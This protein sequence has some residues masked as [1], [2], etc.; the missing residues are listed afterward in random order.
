M[1]LP[2]QAAEDPSRATPPL[3]AVRRHAA[4]GTQ[5]SL[6]AE[7]RPAVPTAITRNASRYVD[8][9]S[10][11]RA[12]GRDPVS[13]N[14][15][16]VCYLRTGEVAEALRLF[17]GLALKPGCTWERSDIPELY[18]RNFATALLMSGLPSGCLA[19]LRELPDQSSP[20]TQQ[21]Y[22]AVR[23]WERT[24]SFWARWD[25]RWNAIEPKGCHV[26]IDFEPGEFAEE[27]PS[28][29]SVG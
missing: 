5:D 17:R 23:R 13:V 11:L 29:R 28:L 18:R 24:L 8:R 19:V 15:L 27:D 16:G 9:I 6:A 4:R 26:P 7:T 12:R 1:N 10:K 21:L 20:R 22:E 2:I 3:D 25:W 14:E